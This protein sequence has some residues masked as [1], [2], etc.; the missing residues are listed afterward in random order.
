MVDLVNGDCW[1]TVGI[2]VLGGEEKIEEPVA[3]GISEDE[4]EEEETEV[5]EP[6]EEGTSEEST[7]TYEDFKGTYAL[8]EGEPYNS[9]IGLGIMV[10]GDDSYRSFNHSDVYMTSTILNKTI[11]GNVLT[12]HS[13]SGTE[14]FKLRYE[15][16]KKIMHYGQ[17]LYSMSSQ[18]LQNSL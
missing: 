14:Q 3:T 13:K 4:K 9:P 5:A 2:A 16:D 17:S 12:L 11:E 6:E 18:D 8:F 1:V 7:Y 15:G 10:I